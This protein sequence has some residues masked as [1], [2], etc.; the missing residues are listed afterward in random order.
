M[1]KIF[2][3]LLL[4][5]AI[6]SGSIAQTNIFCEYFANYDSTTASANYNGWTLTYF[7]AFSY[8]T[9]T[10]SSGP[11]GPNSYKFGV[12]SA[13]AITP[14]ILGADSIHFHMKGNASTGGSLAN[15]A[16]YIY[17]T[18]DGT[19][20]SLVDMIN[21]IPA[22]VATMKH[23][24]ISAGTTNVKFFYDKDSG[25][26]AFDDFCATQSVVGVNE[27]SQ[28]AAL[29]VYPNPTKGNTT[30]D[31][32][33]MRSKNNVTVVVNNVLGKEI[34]RVILKGTETNFQLDLSDYQDGV[35][36][37]KVKSDSG[38]STQRIVLRK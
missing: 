24:K 32:K 28:K 18:S 10:Q 35:Y 34:N 17:E 11:S 15:G 7:S 21:P 29:S 9:S 8:Y 20:Y 33:N 13:T 19:N 22:G 36:F 38:E 37:V 30:I 1:R 25:N 31:F 16:F 4:I 6:T 2:T 27:L 12:D 3:I 14:N 5:T 23:Y 26:V